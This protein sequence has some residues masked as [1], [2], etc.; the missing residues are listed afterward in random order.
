MPDD[1]GS[2]KPH[3]GYLVL[4]L[5]ILGLWAFPPLCL[6]ALVMGRN[7][8][9]AMSNGGMD[10]SGRTITTIGYAL[11]IAGVVLY[12]VACCVLVGMLIYFGGRLGG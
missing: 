9:T 4:V 11:S 3:R 6:P 8:L 10:G 1:N 5:G 12:G 7:D 2:I